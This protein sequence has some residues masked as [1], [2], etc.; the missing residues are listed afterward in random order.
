MLQVEKKGPAPQENPKV[1]TSKNQEK[2]AMEE[3]KELQS[4]LV[5]ETPAEKTANPPAVNTKSAEVDWKAVRTMIVS[6][7]DDDNWDDGS[8]GPIFVRLAWHA[9]GTYDAKNQLGGSE[10][11]LMRFKP[12]ADWGANAG[13]AFARSRLEPVKK[14]FPD[15]SFADLWSFAGTVAIEEMGGPKIAWRPGRRDV[16][17]S[18]K[19]KVNPDGLLPDADGRD[20]KDRVGDHLRDIFYRMGFNDREIVALSGAH[21][22]GRCHVDRSG[23]WG[24]WT[25][26]P[27]TVS[28]E[29]YRLL[30]EEKW[31][32]KT[33]H[34]GKP[35]TGP[36]QY[37]DKTGSLMMLPT[38]LAL[39]QDAKFRPIVEEYAKNEKKFMDDFGKAWLKLQENGVRKFHGPRRYWLF[40][41]RE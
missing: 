25:F 6:L 2:I 41:P 15:I 30:V 23:Y 33:T 7:L 38:D 8:W 14:A 5:K 17:E 32:P 4:K 19:Y 24:P 35:W 37:E 20:K 1:E 3:V 39:I 29:Y 13:L 31:T 12:E 11:A 22:L 26:A 10:G 9:A 21:S 18:E 34:M 27:T 28:N 16:A 40:G 36:L